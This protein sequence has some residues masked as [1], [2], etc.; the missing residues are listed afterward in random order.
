MPV[1]QCAWGTG[2]GSEQR[3]GSPYVLLS[4]AH[5]VRDNVKVLVA[6]L[7]D[8]SEVK[9]SSIDVHRH[10]TDCVILA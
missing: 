5:G 7:E 10:L 3:A 6:P 4:L 8:L 1:C 9:K 2:L